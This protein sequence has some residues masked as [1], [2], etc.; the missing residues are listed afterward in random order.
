[1][2]TRNRSEGGGMDQRC[3]GPHRSRVVVFVRGPVKEKGKNQAH[4][5]I[6]I[7]IYYTRV[8]FHLRLILGMHGEI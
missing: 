7:Y 4:S 2:A 8:E 3:Y 1:M 5:L 6:Y